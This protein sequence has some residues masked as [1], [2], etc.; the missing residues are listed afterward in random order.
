MHVIPITCV[1]EIGKIMAVLCLQ[2]PTSTNKKLGVMI[3]ACD[4]IGKHKKG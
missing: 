1:A 3:H 4:L 2:D